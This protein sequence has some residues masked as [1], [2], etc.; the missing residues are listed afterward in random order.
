MGAGPSDFCIEWDAENRLTRVLNNGSEVV[1]Y[2]YD[3]LGRR[4]EKTA[5]GVTTSFV[6]AGMDVLEERVGANTTRYVHGPNMDQ[7]WARID[8]S[9][10]KSYYV[11]D[12]LGSIV[13]TTN[14]SATVTLTR[15]YDPWGNQLQGSTTGGYAYTGREWDPATQTSYYRARDYD[16]MAGRF[17]SED[18][19]GFSGG[20]NPYAYAD[21][22]PI[23]FV[24]PLGLQ[25]APVGDVVPLPRPP[26][27]VI[28]GP[29]SPSNPTPLPGPGTPWW[30]PW[31]IVLT[32]PTPVN[33]TPDEEPW[34]G[35]EYDRGCAK[36]RAG[37]CTCWAS[38]SVIEM[39]AGAKGRPRPEHT[40]AYG[41]GSNCA[42]ASTN[43]I[44]NAQAVLQQWIL[45]HPWSQ[46][47]I[48]V[49]HC[50]ARCPS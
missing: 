33:E 30:L 13:Q 22:N 7:H 25:A 24:D 49:K 36:K 12:H 50:R 48:R 21:A 11:A 43:A 23:A 6:L 17:L 46:S 47:V 16:S 41:T 34:Q 5:G 8:P 15:E 35:P 20:A 9:G 28:Q 26:G 39:G 1:S 40:S 44:N 38:C 37:S 2:K 31:W 14:T 19:I 42:I 3:G 10:A 32:T 18:P 27:Q 29:W 45:R 4:T